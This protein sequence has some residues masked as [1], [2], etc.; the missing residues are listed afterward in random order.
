MERPTGR[1]AGSRLVDAGG[2]PVGRGDAFRVARSHAPMTRC[3]REPIAST[4]AASRREGRDPGSA[5]VREAATT[6]SNWPCTPM[7]YSEPIVFA[8]VF[9][10]ASRRPPLTDPS[11]KAAEESQTPSRASSGRRPARLSAVALRCRSFVKGVRRPRTLV[12]RR[13]MTR[14]DLSRVRPL[15]YFF[16]PPSMRYF[17]AP[18]GGP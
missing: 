9:V 8:G 14:Q 7:D 3:S 17:F 15:R 10:Y 6:E 16:A 4:W 5:T 2:P 13:Q 18:R 12:A 11:P 1:D